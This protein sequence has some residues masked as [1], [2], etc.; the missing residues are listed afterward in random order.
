MAP[1][2]APALSVVIPAYNAASTLG[3]QLDALRQQRPPVPVEIV[4]VDN[5]STDSTELVVHGRAVGDD[6]IRLVSEP[7][8]GAAAALNRG[9]S[10]ARADWMAFCDADDVVSDGWIEA[11]LRGL[12]SHEIV[13][14]PLEL[15]RLNDPAAAR[16]RGSNW[17]NRLERFADVFPLVPSGNFAA[18]RSAIEAANGFDPQYR[19]GYDVDFSYRAFRAGLPVH[20]DPN[21]I[22][23]YRYRRDA[24]SQWEQGRAM[25][26]FRPGLYRRLRR[27]GHGVPPRLKGLMTWAWLVRSLPS[28][29]H[30]AGRLRW[31]WV[32]ANRVGQLEGSLRTRSLFP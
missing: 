9:I 10:E 14:G 7:R 8:K 29:R 3:E 30:R 4:V 5:G 1:P 15:D 24:R 23:H 11:A 13:T 25:G 21:L 18:H 17:A 32:A 16:S 26:R 27:D 31:V 12:A 6:R 20:F 2:I 28:V 19:I 22:L